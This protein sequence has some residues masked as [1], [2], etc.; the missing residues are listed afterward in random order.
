MTQVCAGESVVL[1]GSASIV[2][3]CTGGTAEYQWYEDG[4][5][6]PGERDSDLVIPSLMGIK[7]GTG[8]R[9]E[10][11]VWENWADGE[12]TV[13]IRRSR[14]TLNI[15]EDVQFTELS[16]PYWFSVGIMNAAAIA[17]STPNGRSGTAY[18]L[19]LSE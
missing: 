6:L 8:S 11:S 3:D 14:A 10:V 17:H 5:L 13:K 9:G 19:I 1:D 2:T 18:Q 12:W 15:A 4:N 16:V 7:P